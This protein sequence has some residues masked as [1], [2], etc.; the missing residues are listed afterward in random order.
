[1]TDRKK[2]GV[3]FW[4]T[5]LLVVVLPMAYALSAGPALWLYDQKAVPRWARKP[6]GWIYSPLDWIAHNGPRPVRSCFNSY[7][8]LWNSKP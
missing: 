8:E 3:A 7:L 5:M 4:A 2:P 6:I 1:M